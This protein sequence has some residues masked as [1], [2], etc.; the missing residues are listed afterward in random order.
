MPEFKNAMEVFQLL[1]KSN[2][3]KCNE[4]TCL[5]FAS[6]VYLGQKRLDQCPSLAPEVVRRYNDHATAVLPRAKELEA[7]MADLKGRL[8]QCDF[9]EAA[10]RTGGRFEQGWLS[11]RIFGKPFSLDRRGRFRTDLHVNPWMV[12]PVMN[13]VLDCRGSEI[14]GKWVPF[15]ELEGAREKNALF[16]RRAEKGLKRIADTYPGLF[17]DLVDMFSGRALERQYEADVSLVL[18]PLPRVPLLICYWEAE[19]GMASDLT[20]FF[21]KSADRNGGSTMVFNL[22]TGMVQMFEKFAVTHGVD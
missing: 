2:C 10:R 9:E 3:R 4:T 14:T 6:K 11:L 12:I 18:Y 1:D 16:V 5:A 8:A 17:R 13:Y 21:D 20:L 7:V 15:R 19:E 22:A